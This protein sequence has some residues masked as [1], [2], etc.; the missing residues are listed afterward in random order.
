MSTLL[1][2]PDLGPKKLNLAEGQYRPFTV[3][4]TGITVRVQC[5]KYDAAYTVVV[6]RR[7]LRLDDLCG[8]Y[9]TEQEACLVARGYCQMFAREVNA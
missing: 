4:G 5:A 2:T 7:T 8:S 1:A 3:A 6:E 9:G